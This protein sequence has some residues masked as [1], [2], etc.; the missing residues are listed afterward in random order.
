[1]IFSELSFLCLFFPVVVAFYFLFKNKVYRNSVLLICSLFFYAWGEPIYVLLMIAVALVA[2]LGGLGISKMKEQPAKKRAILISTVALITLNLLVFKYTNFFFDN[3]GLLVGKKISI[4]QIMLPI[5]ISFYTFQILSYVIDL[6]WGNVKTQ[7][8]FFYLLLYMSFFPQLIAGPI[9]RYSTVEFEI[10]NR[11]ENWSE[12]TEGIRRFIVGLAKKVII[13]N[14]VA[15]ISEIIYAGN[16]NEYGTIMYWL[17][18]IAYTMQLYFDFSAYSDMAIGIGKLFGFHFLENFNYPY[19]ATSI[20]DFWRRWHISLSTWFRDYIYIPL[21]GNRVTIGRNIFNLSVVWILTGFWHGASW[22]FILWGIYY[23]VLLILEKFVLNKVLSKLPKLVG[24]IYQFTIVNIGWVL[25]NLTDFS[26][27]ATALKTM[28][29]Y[30]PT[31]W[32]KVFTNNVNILLALIYIPVAFIAAVPILPAVKKK[33][34]NGVWSDVLQN[35]GCILLFA[36]S[37]I[38][39]LSSDYNPFIYFRF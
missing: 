16:P 25:F 32:D 5:G 15:P 30:V 7:R 9:V 27:L 13:A 33:I 18:A 26:K 39:I 37:L 35:V 24:W 8:N 2:Y 19:I 17:A 23:G 31:Q 34:G 12:A 11:K 20:T 1:M 29:F 22:N 10:E 21:G 28:L 4:S 3:L 38:F 14:H 6:Y 36:L